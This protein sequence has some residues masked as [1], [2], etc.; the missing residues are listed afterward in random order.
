MADHTES[1]KL[2]AFIADMNE[3]STKTYVTREDIFLIVACRRI[4]ETLTLPTGNPFLK[5]GNLEAIFPDKRL[6]A[7]KT[8]L[9]TIV[10]LKYRNFP[11]SGKSCRSISRQLQKRDSVTFGDASILCN[12][13]AK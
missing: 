12:G 13:G 9:G 5:G 11:R 4:M 3:L 6:M 7:M 2:F 1:W 10:E 8:L